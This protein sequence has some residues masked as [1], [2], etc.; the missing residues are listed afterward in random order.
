MEIFGE[1]ILPE[2]TQFGDYT[3]LGGEFLRGKN[4]LVDRIYSYWLDKH[5]DGY[6]P[7]RADIKPNEL[8]KYLDHLV[9]MDVMS[10]GDSFSLKVRLIGTHVANFYGEI[11]GK[12][13]SDMP[14]A[15]AAERIYH[16]SKLV[17][18]NKL[19]QLSITAAVAPGRD[20]LEAYALYLPLYDAAGEV[21]KI[22][23]A[24]D[25]RSDGPAPR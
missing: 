1:G 17:L 4:P 12:D 2:G 25:V 19:P 16:L 11:A 5:A 20:Y 18:Q 24:V 6:L 9:I 15:K 10:E 7:R 14:N 8:I 22:L 3:V 21:D 13:V 23:V